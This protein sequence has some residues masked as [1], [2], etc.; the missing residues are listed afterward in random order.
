MKKTVLLSLLFSVVL[1]LD[2][3]SLVLPQ[4]K[5]EITIQPQQ[6][7]VKAQEPDNPGTETAHCLVLSNYE[8]DEISDEINALYERGYRLKGYSTVA[9]RGYGSYDVLKSFAA[10]CKE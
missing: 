9:A 2:I 4:I 10:V 7:A 8:V 6:A 3:F 1:F 5:I